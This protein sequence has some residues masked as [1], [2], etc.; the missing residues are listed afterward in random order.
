[1]APGKIVVWLRLRATPS[2]TLIRPLPSFFFFSFSLWCRIDLG[3]RDLT[4]YM[5]ALLVKANDVELNIDAATL[6]T[7]GGD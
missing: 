7:P 4:M 5:R 3:G 2:A 6:G 1:M